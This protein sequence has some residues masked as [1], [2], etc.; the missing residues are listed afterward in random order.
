MNNFFQPMQCSEYSA[1]KIKPDDS[2]TLQQKL[3]GICCIVLPDNRYQTRQGKFWNP[4][5]LPKMPK[6]TTGYPLIGEFHIDGQPVSVV[7]E[8][9]SVNAVARHP[10]VDRVSY[11]VFDVA[12]PDITDHAARA[13]A[14]FNAGFGTMIPYTTIG[15]KLDD[16]LGYGRTID[17]YYNFVVRHGGEG[18]VIREHCCPYI[19]GTVSPVQWKRK[20]VRTMEVV[21]TG[22][23]RGLG[24]YRNTLGALICK[25][26]GTGSYFTVAGMD[27]DWRD[28]FWMC[29]TQYLNTTVTIAYDS[30]SVNGIPLKPRVKN[31]RNYE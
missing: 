6:N 11:T 15:N 24:K 23:Q 27:N 1:D 18:I 16:A 17:D 10:N 26:P 8:Y 13:R 9:V 3:D 19:E 21:I 22:Y 25:V 28:E 12:I 5:F 2:Y 14:A 20:A 29:K 4:D 30:L 7:M 31:L